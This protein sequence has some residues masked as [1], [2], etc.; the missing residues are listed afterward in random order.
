L[1]TFDGDRC[2]NVLAVFAAK[3]LAGVVCIRAPADM[4]R[5]FLE[6]RDDESIA[7]IANDVDSAAALCEIRQRSRRR[8][9]LRRH[10]G[11]SSV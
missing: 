3:S 2:A 6:L 10:G 4:L 1:R 8:R 5:N 9:M 7:A 11:S